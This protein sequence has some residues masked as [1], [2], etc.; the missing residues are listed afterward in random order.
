MLAVIV[1]Q[2]AGLWRAWKGKVAG[3]RLHV[4]I[5]ALFSLIAALPALLLTLAA[6]STF[7]RALD[8]WFDEQTT[9]LV[10]GATDVAKAYLL[11]HG[12][13]IRTDIVNMARDLDEAAPLVGGDVRNFAR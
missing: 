11:E 2:G 9:A 7:S 3:A 1:V 8:S 10:Q 6:T 13:I 12:A 4:R 5:V